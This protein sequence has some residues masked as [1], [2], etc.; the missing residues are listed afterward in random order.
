MPTAPA[1]TT[2]NAAGTVLTPA[3]N[4]LGGRSKQM[5]KDSSSDMRE[6]SKDV[7]KEA[8]GYRRHPYYC[9]GDPPRLTV[10]FGRN[11]EQVG[12]NEEEAAVLFDHDF[13]RAENIV[14]REAWWDAASDQQRYA[15]L[16]MVFI[17]GERG[18]RR[19]LR[20]HAALER[21]DWM[22]AAAE[23]LD[24][25]MHRQLRRRTERIAEW[26]SGATTEAGG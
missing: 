2:A 7:I 23:I 9:T 4:Q 26:T 21:G 12:I 1:E 6:R 18:W 20:M 19:F 3:Q 22:Q 13:A 5:A 8:E 16:E 11:L 24:S 10:G 17:L 25:K 15:Q 14:A